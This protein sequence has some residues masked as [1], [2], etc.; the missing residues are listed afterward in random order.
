MDFASIF[1]MIIGMVG[2][3]DILEIINNL[4][5][6]VGPLIGELLK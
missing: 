2:G 1:E 5:G 6:M 3:T 4:L